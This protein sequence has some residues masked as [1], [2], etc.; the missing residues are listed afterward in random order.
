MF[1]ILKQ[2]NDRF[3]PFRCNKFIFFLGIFL[4]GIGSAYYHLNPT[5]NTLLWDRLPM[6]I[7]FMSFFSIIIGEFVCKNSG[8]NFLLPFLTLG[9]LSL[10]YWQMT[11]SRGCADLRFYVLIQFLPMILIPIILITY[12]VKEDN[13][14]LYWHI[15]FMYVFAKMFEATDHT[16]YNSGFLVSGHSIKHFAAAVAPLLLLIHEKKA[17]EC[18]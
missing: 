16:I 8:R 9:C 14:K 3:I 12:K 10:I 4:T 2:N 13:S 15:L 11:A 6:T 18:L 17:K 7:A 1:F 5:N